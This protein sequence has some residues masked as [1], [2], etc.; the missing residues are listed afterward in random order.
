[1]SHDPERL[2]LETD[3]LRLRPYRAADV[4]DLHRLWTDEDVRRFLWDGECIPWQRAAATVLDAVRC[5]AECGIGQWLVLPAE[6]LYGLAPAHWGRGL[7]TEAA[8]ALVR[9]GF[10]EHGLA[11]IIAICDTP[12]TGSVRLMQRLGMELD[13]TLQLPLG[14]GVRYVLTRAA[15]HTPPGVYIVRRA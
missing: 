10:E 7:A 11:R 3:R 14:P 5:F 9:L 1:M 15:Y 4:D 2:T 12:N 8:R 6:L 13:G